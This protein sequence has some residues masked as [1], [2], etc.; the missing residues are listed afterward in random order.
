MH[1]HFNLQIRL[2]LIIHQKME[3]L[4]PI[5]R[6]RFREILS[7]VFAITDDVMLD[8]I[9]RTFDQDA[10]GYVRN[11]CFNQIAK[12]RLKCRSFRSTTLNGSVV[13]P[14][15]SVELSTSLLTTRTP[16]TT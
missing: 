7:V 2:L 3:E 5:D 8:L 9:F 10:D 4:G 14:P 15:C 16:S 11:V 13:S 12:K 1:E 6:T